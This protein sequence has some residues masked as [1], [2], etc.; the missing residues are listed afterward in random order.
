MLFIKNGKL[1]TMT[2]NGVIDADILVENGKIK[3]VGKDLVVPLNA[4]VIDADGCYV[5]PGFV[6]AHCHIGLE[7][8]GIGFEGD[9][10]NEMTDPVTP[11]LRAIDCINPIDRCFDEAVQGGVTCVCT[12]PGSGNVIGGQ[13]AII[14]T[15]GRRIDDMVV[16]APAA[17]KIAFG[18]N[19]KRVYHDQKKSPMTR[20][21]TAAIL[22][23]AL[24]KAKKYV[25]KQEAAKNGID[26]EPEF[27]MK[28]EALA[29]VIRKEIPLKAHA[30]RADDIFTA[31][32]IAKE[33]DVNI[34]LDHC[35]EGHLIA[36]YLAE[37]G[38]YAIA[39]PSLGHRTKFE[40]K[41]QSFETPAVLNKAGVKFS[42]TTDSPV[43]PLQFLPLCAGL[44]VKAGLDEME[45]LKAITI[46]PATILGIDDKV[47]SLEVGKDADILVCKGNPIK[48]INYKTIATIIDGEVVYRG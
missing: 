21:A 46:N 19:P 34:T 22:R 9:D 28:M 17:M 26:K 20:M 13:F 33:F 48:D 2:E 5:M 43:I 37:E 24:F 18:E 15:H 4:D 44:A 40:L 29:K 25:N 6:E 45:A 35:T 10:V 1:F 32:R 12:G 11:H 30:H 31:L 38:R 7:E 42:I 39:G 3:E 36:D 27:D 8:D 47:G 23:E 16:K 14:K 41:N